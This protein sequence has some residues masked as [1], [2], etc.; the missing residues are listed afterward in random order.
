MSSGSRG[1]FTFCQL[2]GTRNSV[3]YAILKKINGKA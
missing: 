1:E 3:W 2:E